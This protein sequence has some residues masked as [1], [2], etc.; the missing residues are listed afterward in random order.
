M[1]TGFG[2]GL[3]YVLGDLRG[4]RYQVRYQ[5]HRRS[6]SNVQTNIYRF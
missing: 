1:A 6:M 2:V 5:Y 3:I 4:S